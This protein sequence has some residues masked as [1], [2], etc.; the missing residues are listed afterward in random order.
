MDNAAWSAAAS[1][2]CV[3]LAWIALHPGQVYTRTMKHRSRDRLLLY[4]V[5]STPCIQ[6]QCSVQGKQWNLV[7]DWAIWL[8]CKAWGVAPSLTHW[9]W[10][11]KLR[12][13]FIWLNPRR[14][15]KPFPQKSAPLNLRSVQLSRVV[16]WREGRRSQRDRMSAAHQKWVF[17]S[18]ER[19]S[20]V[21]RSPGC[22]KVRKQWQEGSAPSHC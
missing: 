17:S 6:Q 8:S 3:V 18:Q 4:D 15:R 14:H 7:L 20:G 5:H 10:T 22:A 2:S 12:G 9:L 21:G 13:I 19:R 16:R 11:A 1:R